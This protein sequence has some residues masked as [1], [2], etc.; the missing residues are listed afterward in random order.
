MSS[1]SHVKIDYYVKSRNSKIG[2]HDV[3]WKQDKRS[4]KTTSYDT[5][6]NFPHV[7]C[8]MMNNLVIDAQRAKEQGWQ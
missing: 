3:Q 8:F 5:N 7:T 4:Q 6:R 2:F 1:K